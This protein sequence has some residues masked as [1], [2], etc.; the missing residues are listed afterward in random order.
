MRMQPKPC[1]P[2]PIWVGG[3]SE[4]AL[5]R[6]VNLCEGWHG[7]RLLPDKAE[8]IIRR[9]RG[10]RPEPAFAISLRT[11]WDGSDPAEL[12]GRLDGFREAGAGH[13]LVEPADREIEDWL[14]SVD[15]IARAAEGLSGAS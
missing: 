10:K 11:G 2:I 12:R 5:E 13:I 9:L 3:S 14:R 15:K 7:S 8:P 4:K 1:A 6:A